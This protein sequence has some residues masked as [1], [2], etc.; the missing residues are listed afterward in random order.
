MT[1]FADLASRA[2]HHDPQVCT[3]VPCGKCVDRGSATPPPTVD[4]QARALIRR[5]PCPY[6]E[7]IPHLTAI[8]ALVP[9]DL[10]DLTLGLASAITRYGEDR[11]QRLLAWETRNLGVSLVR[12]EDPEPEPGEDGKPTRPALT[13]KQ[14]QDRHDDTRA[15]S[16]AQDA[17]DTTARLLELCHAPQRSSSHL[18]KTVV[19]LRFLIAVAESR[20]PRQLKSREIQAAQAA[21]DGWCRSCFRVGVFEPI[22]TRPGGEPFYRDLCRWCGSHKGTADQPPVD[23]LRIHHRIPERRK[24][25]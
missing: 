12:E 21:A 15:A 7:L 6:H 8:A 22:Q 20:K 9:H 3:R 16:Y 2:P 4:H 13:S 23:M 17:R 5:E 24:A 14:E 1:D 19:H 25:S 11:W 10:A 18:R